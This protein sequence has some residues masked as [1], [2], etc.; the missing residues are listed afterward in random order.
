VTVQRPEVHGS[1]R[2]PPLRQERQVA[3]KSA[4]LAGAGLNGNKIGAIIAQFFSWLTTYW[5]IEWV[6]A[7]AAGK[8][9]AIAVVVSIAIEYL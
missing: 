5:A 4:V 2:A 3:T 7:P 8:D 1:P 9:E 6:L